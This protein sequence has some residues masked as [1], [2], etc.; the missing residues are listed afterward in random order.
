MRTRGR[1]CS[2]N[3]RIPAELPQVLAVLQRAKDADVSSGW[4]AYE[5]TNIR[6]LWGR[7]SLIRKSSSRFQIR[8]DAIYE[9]Q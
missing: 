7:S 4:E 6:P 2:Q 3:D 8:Y 5:I 9:G 1:A